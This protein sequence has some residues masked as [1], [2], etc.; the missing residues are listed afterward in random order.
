MFADFSAL[1][2]NQWI[3]II[4]AV[5][6]C[7][8]F[9]AWTILDAWKRDFESANEKVLWMQICIFVPILGSL[10]YLFLGRKRGSKRV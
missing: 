7:F 8:S 3:V 10:A 5:A 1:T 2:T 9:S 6:A 4:A